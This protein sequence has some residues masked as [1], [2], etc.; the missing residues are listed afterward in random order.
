VASG[1][2]LRASLGSIRL[3]IAI[4]RCSARLSADASVGRGS[5]A[6]GPADVSGD[7]WAIWK[8]ASR[9]GRDA[10]QWPSRS[11]GRA[12]PLLLYCTV[13]F[14]SLADH[15]A[16]LCFGLCCCGRRRGRADPASPNHSLRL[17]LSRAAI[18]GALDI[19]DTHS[20]STSPVHGWV[21]A[22][23]SCA[24]VAEYCTLL[25]PWTNA[26]VSLYPQRLQSELG[27]V[28]R[29]ARGEQTPNHVSTV[30]AGAQGRRF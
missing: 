19:S 14:L 30:G 11:G 6:H 29:R 18:H 20:L 25:L 4:L 9:H 7:S 2:C 21:Y 12:L 16:C 15:C 22:P 23:R 17:S 26:G 10:E 13:S 24:Y 8:R 1:G 5:W 28:Y 3:E 27:T